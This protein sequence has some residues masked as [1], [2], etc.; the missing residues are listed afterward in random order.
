[1]IAAI[2][3]CTWGAPLPLWIF[4]P[5]LFLGISVGVWPHLFFLACGGERWAGQFLIAL[6]SSLLG[7]FGLSFL[8]CLL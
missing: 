6:V 1:M 7:F 4:F 3:S 5:L 2:G 8:S